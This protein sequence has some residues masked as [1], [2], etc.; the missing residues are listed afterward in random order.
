MFTLRK[1]IPVILAM[2]AQMQSEMKNFQPLDELTGTDTAIDR[3][4]SLMV[5]SERQF[6]QLWRQHKEIFG[7]GQGGGVTVVEA[8]V[9]KVDFK[10]NVVFVYFGGQGQG[11]DGYDIGEINTKGKTA[12][13]N[14]VPHFFAGAVISNS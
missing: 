5:T 1:A 7:E 10:K 13:V 14:I 4:M 12:T 2:I 6:V 3:Q 11:I 8:Q 9:P